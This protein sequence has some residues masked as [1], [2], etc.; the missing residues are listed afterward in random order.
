MSWR[1]VVGKPN[2][3]YWQDKNAPNDNIGKVVICCE[4][5][6]TRAAARKRA[7]EFSELGVWNYSV[8]KNSPEQLEL[9]F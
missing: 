2:K 4:N 5:I 6:S 7:K 1:I 3:E 9:E 8:K